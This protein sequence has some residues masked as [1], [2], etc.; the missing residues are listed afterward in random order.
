MLKQVKFSKLKVNAG[1]TANSFNGPL[2]VKTSKLKAYEVGTKDTWF[3]NWKHD[4]VWADDSQIKPW[5]KLW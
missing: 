4:K 2:F 1:F 3:G 5:W